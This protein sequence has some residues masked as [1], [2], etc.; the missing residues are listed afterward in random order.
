MD[1]SIEW[2]RLKV[3]KTIAC[4]H[5]SL[6]LRQSGWLT[7]GEVYP[8]YGALITVLDG[9]ADTIDNRVYTS[10][11][12]DVV[13]AIKSLEVIVEALGVQTEQ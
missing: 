12:Q 11:Y 10:S 2:D 13:N 7:T 9:I 8:L 6:M 3:A 4:C 1:E 5:R